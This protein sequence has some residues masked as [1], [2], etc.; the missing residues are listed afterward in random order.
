[1]HGATGSG[2]GGVFATAKDLLAFNNALRQGRL[3]NPEMTAWVM[4][5]DANARMSIAGGAP[6]TNAVLESDGT[7]AIIVTANVSGPIAESIASAI[8]VALMR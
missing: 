2:A 5:G 1:M 3:L 4:R 6:G 7:W 8:A